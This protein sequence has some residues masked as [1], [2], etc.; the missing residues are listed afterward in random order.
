[1]IGLGQFEAPEDVLWAAIA[2]TFDYGRIAT[3]AYLQILLLA[4]AA[5]ASGPQDAWTVDDS[6][7]ALTLRLGHLGGTA[8]RLSARRLV[9][10]R[11]LRGGWLVVHL[12]SQPLGREGL[13]E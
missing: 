5:G 7:A 11:C 12:P 10:R 1:Q 3:W 8:V 2:G 4:L 13:S 6:R 9:R